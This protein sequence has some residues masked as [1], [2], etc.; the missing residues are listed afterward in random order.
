MKWLD[1]VK[2]LAPIILGTINP[3]L[4]ALA[5]VITAGITEA[6]GISGATGAQKLDHV[7]NLATAAANGINVAAGKPLIDVASVTATAGAAISAV[8]DATNIVHPVVK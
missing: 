4:G 3:H 6:E 7:V 2:I 8:V 1:L 5:P